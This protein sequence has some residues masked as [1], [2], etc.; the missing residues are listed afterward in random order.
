MQNINKS[1][2]Y[3]SFVN[4]SCSSQP[5]TTLNTSSNINSTQDIPAAL[6]NT[7]SLT[8]QPMT[9][10]NSQI[11]SLA[12]RPQEIVVMNK[13][14]FFYTPCNDFQMY[15]IIC[16]EIPLTFELVSQLLNNIDYNCAQSN[17]IYVFYHE[18]PEI[19]KIYRVTC[20]MIS[21]T[22]L[23][24]FLNKIIYNIQFTQYEYQRQEFSTKHQENLKLYLKKDLIHYLTPK[25]L[26]EDNCDLNKKF[27]QDYCTY[28]SMINSNTDTLNHS[29]K[30]NV[31]T[32]PFDQSFNNNNY[33]LVSFQNDTDN[34]NQDYYNNFFQS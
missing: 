8:I 33:Q 11:S 19:K 3:P 29:Q 14:S 10:N 24:Q 30:Y 25:N 4:T 5:D 7:L 6:D 9:P 13:S 32:F 28:E 26:H 22:F 1:I 16:E 21:H 2:N 27:I 31:N 12:A 18:Q 20:E 15:H 23:F 17:N 34:Y